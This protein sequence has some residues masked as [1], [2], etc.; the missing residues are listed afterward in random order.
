MAGITIQKNY[1]SSSTINTNLSNNW[2]VLVFGITD[3]GPKTPTLIQ[4]Y[5]NFTDVFGQAS[6]NTNVTYNYIKFL[7]DNGVP[8]LFKRI[9][10]DEAN[11]E[12][13]TVEFKTGDKVLAN[14][15]ATD[16]YIGSLGNDI[17]VSINKDTANKL[18]LNVTYK[19]V[20][21]ET[22]LLGLITETDTIAKLIQSFFTDKADKNFS[23]YIYI[24]STTLNTTDTDWEKLTAD[25][26]PVNLSLAGG[27]SPENNEVNAI[28]I[29]KD[30]TKEFWQDKKLKN[31][32][33]YYPQLRFATSGGIIGKKSDQDIINKNL[34]QFAVDCGSSFRIL[35]DYSLDEVDLQT[36]R[37][38]ATTV[39]DAT[40][41][42]LEHY[43]YFGF[44]GSDSAGNWLP[45]SAG[46]LTA[47]GNSDYNVYNRRIAG[48]SFMPAFTKTYRDVY[49][50]EISN[51]QVDSGIQ[52]NPITIIDAQDNLAIMGSSTLVNQISTTIRNPAQALDILLVGDYVAALLNKIALGELESALDRLSLN[53]LSNRMS[54]E[55]EKFVES[56]AITRYSFTFDTTQL[57]KLGVDC[58]L[59]FAIGLEEVSLTVTSIYDVNAIS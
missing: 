26:L 59:Y 56:R 22:Y 42:S 41:V 21:K 2:S 18:T 49:I 3:K 51:W 20:L 4:T 15:T 1:V 38:F 40:K 14:I 11:Y 32:I 45:G 24:P 5:K 55:V 53:S 29:L 58:V 6:A 39:N 16:S 23:D 7:L 37:N 28:N 17:A 33:T 12:K 8:V 36:I 25:S 46:F 52:L 30:Y 43:S 44:W 57:G 19:T 54:Q 35:V 47:L 27:T 48:T 50:D 9:L 34:G 31:A 10:D 13:A